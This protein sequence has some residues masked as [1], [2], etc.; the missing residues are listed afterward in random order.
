MLH[1]SIT[2]QAVVLSNASG[3]RSSATSISDTTS[4]LSV[5]VLLM[6]AI[7]KAQVRA[8]LLTIAAPIA[9]TVA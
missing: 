3:N 4:S 9:V 5:L 2:T 8:A 7:M 1:M 6:T